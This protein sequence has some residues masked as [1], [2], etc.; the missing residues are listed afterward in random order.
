[1]KYELT[2]ETSVYSEF[3]GISV[4]VTVTAIVCDDLQTIDFYFEADYDGWDVIEAQDDFFT[5]HPKLRNYTI[6]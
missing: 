4:D 5:F 1:M 6:L 3:E 2:Y